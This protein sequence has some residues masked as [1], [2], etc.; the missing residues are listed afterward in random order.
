[1]VD[2]SGWMFWKKEEPKQTIRAEH[3]EKLLIAHYKYSMEC[4]YV[5]Q[6]MMI[7]PKYRHNCAMAEMMFL[8]ELYLN[9]NYLDLPT[10]QKKILI[11][12]F[13][14]KQNNLGSVDDYLIGFESKKY[15]DTVLY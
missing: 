14:A 7:L 13:V 11:D 12:A 2:W 6:L 3:L 8:G 5:P 4:K 10:P 15:R 9:T 1:M